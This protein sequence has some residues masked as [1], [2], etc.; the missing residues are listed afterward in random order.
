MRQNSIQPRTN[1]YDKHPCAGTFLLNRPTGLFHCSTND[2]EKTARQLPT[3]RPLHE[4]FY[5]LGNI[6]YWPGKKDR[7]EEHTSELQSH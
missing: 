5:R 2:R 7:S 1:T 3:L 6:G 4:Q